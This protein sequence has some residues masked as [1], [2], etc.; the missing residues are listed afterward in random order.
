VKAGFARMRLFCGDA[1]VI[2]IHPFKIEQRVGE[3]DAVYE[4]LYVYDPAAIGRQCATVKLT[5]FSDKS[6]E[7][8]DTRV[9]DPKIL[10][11]IWR[12]FAVQHAAAR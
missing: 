4:G 11:Q 12:D 8:G 2:P 10:E 3:N 5:L 1:E 6:P 7:K 9:I